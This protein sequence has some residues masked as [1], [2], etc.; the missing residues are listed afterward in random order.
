MA[1]T[2]GNALTAA[3][4]VKGVL[5]ALKVAGRDPKDLHLGVVG[6]GGNIC[7]VIAEAL[8][9]KFAHTTIF[10]NSPI[11]QAPK[12]QFVMKKLLA[13]HP[14]AASHLSVETGL[15]AKAIQ[16]DV[17]VLGT[18][19]IFPVVKSCHV[20]EGSVVLDISVPAA[21]EKQCYER[22]DIMAFQGG[23]A[24]FPLGQSISRD[25]SLPMPEGEAFCCLAET[26]SRGLT[27][28]TSHGIG[29]L[30]L[31]SI[32][33]ADRIATEAGFTLGTTKDKPLF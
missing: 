7:S 10:H 5:E 6:A 32:I 15:D 2:T 11:Q 24:R 20:K 25:V 21:L 27:G 23:F 12:L 4:A 28:T 18:N 16:C 8:L 19:S 30:T 9:P 33:E 14:S 17:L 31:E 26:I 22:K 13:T 1:I 3:Y 29:N